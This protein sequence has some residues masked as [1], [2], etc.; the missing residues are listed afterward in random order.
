MSELHD[1][2][3]KRVRVWDGPHTS[4]FMEGQVIATIDGPSIVVLADDGTRDTYPYSLPRDVI[5]TWT[6]R[7]GDVIRDDTS[8]LFT[9]HP[10]RGWF[11]LQSNQNSAK[12]PHTEDELAPPLVLVV[13]DGKPYTGEQPDEA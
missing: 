13:R 9:W 4:V 2:L 11:G 6:W 7:R 5:P 8:N 1:L 3:G 12:G 10:T